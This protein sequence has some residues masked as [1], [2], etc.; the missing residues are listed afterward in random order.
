M[1]I[2]PQ[3]LVKMVNHPE[4]TVGYSYLDSTEPT[5]MP[6]Q[7]PFFAKQTNVRH[8]ENMGKSGLAA[9]AAVGIYCRY[10]ITACRPLAAGYSGLVRPL[11]LPARS[12]SKGPAAPADAAAVPMIQQL[13]AACSHH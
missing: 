7:S 2:I 10:K 11:L 12:P 9:E 1:H 3:V 13:Q 8:T 6:L 5:Q 4:E